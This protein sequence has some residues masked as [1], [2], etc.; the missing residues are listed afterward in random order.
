MC[1]RIRMN[2]IEAL[3]TNSS[4]SE[5]IHEIKNIITYAENYQLTAE[6]LYEEKKET[7]F[8]TYQHTESVVERVLFRDRTHPVDSVIINDFNQKTGADLEEVKM[9]Y[10]AGAD[11][12]TRSRHA[13]AIVLGDK[14]YFRNG[15]YKP[16]T[17][18]GR[19]LLVH[20]LTHIAQ[21]KNREAYR[22]TSKEY[23]ENEAEANEKTEEYSTDPIITK[24]I[25]NR[26]YTVR[27]SE[28][29]KI[30]DI[31]YAKLECIIE[32]KEQVLHEEAYLSLLCKYK[33]WLET[34]KQKW[35]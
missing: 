28:W 31:S 10:G 2:Y 17:E 21:N 33:K 11:E 23:L 35:Q 26:I 6:T 8:T 16:E 4:F 29:E 14:I 27:K 22:M 19:K 13:L 1:Y 12:Y 30:R 5:L 34:E 15:A 18:E 24:R 9:I 20:E 3:E 32:G 25:G 7:K